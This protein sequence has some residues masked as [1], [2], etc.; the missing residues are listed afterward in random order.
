MR[1][2]RSTWARRQFTGGSRIAVRLF[3]FNLLLLFLPIAGILYLDVYETQLLNSQERSMVQQG[4]LVAAAMASSPSFD[5]V[6]ATALVSATGQRGDARIRIYDA[7]GALLADSNAVSTSD[8]SGQTTS[9]YRPASQS[10]RA[11]VLYRLGASI[12]R[13]RATIA[14]W[15]RHLLT[16]SSVP[17][18][19]EATR[20]GL[21]REVS[22]ALQGR[23]GAA[24]RHTPGQRSLTLSSAVPIERDGSIQGAVLV[25]QSTFRVLQAL[26]DVRLR[27]FEVVLGSLA[28]A[29]LLTALAAATVVRPLRRLRGEAT[30]LAERRDQLPG[31]FVDVNRRDEL[32][33]LARALEELT[34][35]LDTHIRDAEQFASDVSHEFK[36]PLASIRAAAEMAAQSDDPADRGRFLSMLARDVDRLERLVSDVRE[37]ARIDSRLQHE[38]VEP[39]DPAS[40]VAEVIQGLR[41]AYGDVPEVRLTAA[42]PRCVVRVSPTGVVQA[43]E[44][45]LAN[46]RSFAPAG[47]DVEVWLTSTHERCRLEVADRGPG[48]PPS[49]LDRVFERFFTYRP[50]DCGQRAYAGLGLAIARS[51]V[52]GYGGT[53]TAR[54]RES[55]GAVFEIT[56]P[57][58]T[59]PG[60]VM[61]QHGHPLRR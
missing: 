7:Q 20:P 15:A 1:I 23:Y 41:L 18:D 13:G 49:H 9:P 30:A 55:G 61:P 19:A 33:D 11:R 6:A 52:E 39:I 43:F 12:A 56:L 10:V 44:N 3:A 57:C 54:N 35:R 51:I 26:Y 2:G 46:A 50:S 31:H 25:S 14:R 27:I 8:D 28:A 58:E 47:T 22:A 24:T 40:L 37:L 16:P 53:I 17:E 21:P 38:P 59:A 45:V 29:A 32:G 34:R 36:N 48:I 4:R 5:A 60:E 42:G